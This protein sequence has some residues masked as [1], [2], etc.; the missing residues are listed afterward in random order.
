VV[1]VMLLGGCVQRVVDDEI[2]QV[3]VD[4]TFYQLPADLPPGAPGEVIRSIPIGGAPAGTV[5]WRL[6]YHT[7]DLAGHDIPASAVLIVPDLPVPEGGRTVVSWGHPTTGAVTKCG[8]SLG[9]DPF[10]GI[11]GMDALLEL[12][13]AVVATDYP[14]MSLAGPSSYLIGVTEGNSML[15]AARAA[16]QLPDAGAGSKVVLWGHS[17][18]GHA[19]LFAAQQAAAYAPDLDLLAVA[20]AAP[21]A[22]LTVLLSDDID[23]HSGVAIASYAF[24]AYEVAYADQYSQADMQAILTPTGQQVAPQIN[25]LCLLTENGKIRAL[26]DPVVD[27]FVTADPSDTEP[28][29]TMIAQNSAGGSPISVPIFVGQGLADQLVVPSSTEGYVQ[30]L[31]AAGEAVSFHEYQGITHLLAAYASLVPMLDWLGKVEHGERPSTC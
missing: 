1:V 6:I 28:W 4:P 21:A 27:D 19:A 18:G 10:L 16:A 5:A 9:F 3:E 8:P 26:A 17:Q 12:G 24:Q 25:D 13:Y 31:C 11:E 22:D 14:G 15:D 7:R 23:D 30:G 20:V 29:K 2:D